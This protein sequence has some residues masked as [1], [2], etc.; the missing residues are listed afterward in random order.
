MSTS[1]TAF[2]DTCMCVLACLVILLLNSA[3]SS[4]R[5]RII[6]IVSISEEERLNTIEWEQASFSVGSVIF[7][8]N[9]ILLLFATLLMIS[10]LT[11]TKCFTLT[12]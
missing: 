9:K 1:S 7:S 10:S 11:L 4:I 2:Y 12:H 5:M 6:I 3:K 8:N